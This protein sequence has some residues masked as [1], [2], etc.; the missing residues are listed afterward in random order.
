MSLLIE[1]LIIFF[2]SFYG[3]HLIKTIFLKNETFTTSYFI[4]HFIVN[5]IITCICI[6]Y[7]LTLFKDPNGIDSEYREYMYIQYTFPI[8]NALH[9]YHLYNCYS[10]IKYDEVIHHIITYVFWILNIHL[11]HPIY[12][13]GLIWLSGVPGGITYLMLYLQK[14]QKVTILQEKYYSMMINFWIRCPGCIIYS[15]L[16]YDR[17]IYMYDGEICPMHVFI[18]GFLMINGIHFTTT[19]VESYYHNLFKK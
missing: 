9:S 16:L 2:I 1:N 3:L 10:N 13:V 17:M 5:F 4:L 8:L 15:T 14:F 11:N 6:P 12:Y 18:I 19:I 7:F